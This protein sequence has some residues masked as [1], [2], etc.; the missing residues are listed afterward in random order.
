MSENIEDV[1]VVVETSGAIPPLKLEEGLF[2]Q[3]VHGPPVFQRVGRP[4]SD[5]GLD[6]CRRASCG[7]ITL[8]VDF[9]GD[10]NFRLPLTHFFG[11]ILSYYGFYTSQFSPLGMVRVRNFK[12]YYCSQGVESTVERFRACYQL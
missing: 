6:R 5:Q 7:Y 11:S 9:F 10:G 3:V 12:V 8:F 2:E 1:V 4:L